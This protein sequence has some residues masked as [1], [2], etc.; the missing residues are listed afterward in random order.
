[1]CETANL[2]LFEVPYDTPF[3]AVARAHSEAIAAQT[4][5]RRSWALDS[6]RALAIAALRPRGLESTLSELAVRLDRW[7]GT[8]D[9]TGL[10]VHEHPHRPA[11]DTDA[12]AARATE[13]I[14]RGGHAS[15][16]L[17]LGTEPF[18]L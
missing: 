11:A 6:Q 5:A 18:T 1:A 14:T 8:F 7:V 9:A 13:L 16:S 12:L 4:Y 17:T 10:L 3:I 15:Q 2:P